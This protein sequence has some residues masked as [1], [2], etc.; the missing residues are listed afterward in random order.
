MFPL[1]LPDLQGYSTDQVDLFFTR[2]KHQFDDSSRN[3]TTASIISSAQFD[4]VQG[5]YQIASV[6]QTLAK[7]ADT[8][9]VREIAQRVIRS[10]KAGVLEELTSNLKEISSLLEQQ[11]SKMFSKARNGYS[12]KLVLEL[13]STVR[14]NRGKLISPSAF[15]IRTKE[16]GRASSGYSRAEVNN[17]CDLLA[18]AVNKQSALS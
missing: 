14:V 10:G 17:F 13:L 15:E 5:G 16:L 11:P 6:D 2:I 12:K 3:L 18:S 8:F 1:G 9:E 4:L 7:L